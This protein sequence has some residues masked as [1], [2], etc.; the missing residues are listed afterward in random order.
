MQKITKTYS[1]MRKRSSSAQLRD[2]IFSPPKPL[3][4][5][6]KIA[7]TSVPHPMKSF[8]YTPT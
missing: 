5:N 3:M 1:F 8:L 4:M 6:L 2:Q 7:E